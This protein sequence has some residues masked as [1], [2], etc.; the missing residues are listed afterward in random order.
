MKTLR[1][2]K[3]LHNAAG[4]RTAVVIDLRRHRGLWEDFVDV[5][6]AKERAVEPTE[7]LAAVRA[8]LRRTGRLKRSA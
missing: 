4:D 8:R 3:Y 1:G 2:V 6:L 5:A 7:S